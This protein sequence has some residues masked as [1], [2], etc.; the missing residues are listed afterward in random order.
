MIGC[1]APNRVETAHNATVAHA[2]PVIGPAEDTAIFIQPRAMVF[3]TWLWVIAVIWTVCR[4]LSV[5]VL[6][7]FGIR[8][9]A[10]DIVT[11]AESLLIV[12]AVGAALCMLAAW[13]KLGWLHSSV[14]GLEF[15]ATGRKAVRLPW[16]EVAAVALRRRGVFTELVVTPAG[17]DGVTVAP[18]PGRRPRMSG[19]SYVVDVGLMSPGPDVLLA[20]LHR[21]I[22]SRV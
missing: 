17:P 10:A 4:G 3:V 14:H 20:E 12:P 18:G 19:D 5:L 2:E 6:L 16:S 13:R 11:I 21:R 1:A 22:P 8:P 15:A 9:T 7:P